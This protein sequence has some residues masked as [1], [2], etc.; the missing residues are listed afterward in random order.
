MVVSARSRILYSEPDEDGNS[1]YWYAETLWEATKNAPIIEI[2]VSSISILDEVVWFGGPNNILPTIRTIA[3]RI[4]AIQE[5]DLAF[6]IIKV[7][8]G[9]ILDGAHRI[10]KAYINKHKFIKAA[11]L[12]EYPIHDGI[13]REGQVAPRPVQK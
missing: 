7:K 3:E 6:P 1:K 5:S 12:D 8:D 4:Q 11:L 9:D 13:V 10:A 2:E